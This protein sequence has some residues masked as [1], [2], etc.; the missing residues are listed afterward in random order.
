MKKVVRLT[1]GDL[2]KIVKRIISESERI[3]RGPQIS[4]NSNLEL[5]KKGYEPY[6]LD[7]KIEYLNSPFSS[8][9][10]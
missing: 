4:Y 2:T 1:E 9:I 10:F 7:L 5:I 3:V 6:Y 8:N